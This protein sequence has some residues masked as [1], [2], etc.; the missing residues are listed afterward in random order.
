MNTHQRINKLLLACDLPG[1]KV[2]DLWLKTSIVEVEY[3]YGALK[4]YTSTTPVH[5]ILDRID[6][7]A[8]IITRFTYSGDL[9]QVGNRLARLERH[10]KSRECPPFFWLGA[11]TGAPSG[12]PGAL[13]TG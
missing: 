10:V 2:L 9:A 1:V 11:D 6:R 3:G 12:S 8:G 7:A 5:D 13:R 4:T